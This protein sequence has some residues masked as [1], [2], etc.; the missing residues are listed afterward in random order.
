VAP[1]VMLAAM[2]GGI[3]GARAL[4][5]IQN[6][7]LEFSG[8]PLDAL[9]V[10]HGGLVFY[11][12]FLGAAITVITW[13]LRKRWPLLAVGDMVAPA[14]PLG[15][16]LGRVGCLLNGCCF[17]RPWHGPLGITYPGQTADGLLNGPLHVQRQLRLVAPDALA[18]V[19]VFPIQ[20]VEAVGNLALCGLLLYLGGR[21]GLRNR[22]FPV[23]LLLYAPLRFAVEFGRGDY[24]QR[25]WGLTSAQW[26]CLV[27]FAVA[28]VW[29]AWNRKPAPGLKPGNTS[30]QA[31]HE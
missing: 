8:S 10:W 12:G 17:G 13:S 4:Y 6:W 3:V 18:C 26:L 22:L 21:P 24:L 30:S 7:D 16:A 23:Y 20:V 9:A 11:G 1:D 27:L 29:L 28:V 31:A 5:V 2:L 25:T 19:P 15:H 14:L